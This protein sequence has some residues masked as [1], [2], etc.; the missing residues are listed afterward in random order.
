MSLLS[1]IRGSADGLVDFARRNIE[2]RGMR[3]EADGDDAV[4]LVDKDRGVVLAKF[5]SVDDMIESY[6][7]KT[8]DL[9]YGNADNYIDA[10]NPTGSKVDNMINLNMGD[11]YGMLPRGATKVKSEGGINYYK[12]GND[13]YATTY[14]PDVGEEDVI[15]YHLSKDGSAELQVVNEMKGKGIG[16]ELSYQFRKNNPEA[17]SGGLSEAGERTARKT[18]DR[19]KAEG[20]VGG[21]AA[22]GLLAASPESEA[23]VASQFIRLVEAGYPESTARKIMSGELPMDFN[24]RMN[25]ARE[26]GRTTTAYRVGGTGEDQLGRL[27][28]DPSAGFAQRAGGGVWFSQDAPLTLSYSRPEGASYKSLLDTSNFGQVDAGG[29]NWNDIYDTDFIFPDGTSIHIDD[30]PELLASQAPTKEKRI[31]IRTRGAINTTDKLGRAAR[32]LGLSGVEIAQVR[33]IGPSGPFML[34]NVKET[35]EG[36]DW[37]NDY[38][39]YGGTN[40]SVQDPSTIRSY[41]GAAF[42]PDEIGNPN[43]MASRAPVGAVGGLLASEAATPEGQLNPLLAIPAEIGSAL[44]EALVGTVDFLGPDTVNAVSELI[45]SEYRMPR[46][47]DQELVRLYSQGGYMD[48]GYGR[49]AIRT[50]TGLLSP[51]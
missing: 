9:I 41:Y 5:N 14:N 16:A 34:K 27:E 15:G 43:I 23:G 29:Q 31:A 33:D 6:G 37:I 44:N 46:L 12:D 3:I 47:S 48:E 21:T 10:I 42:D 45:G 17:P 36:K 40:Y 19:L 13:F 1:I 18:Y 24:S 28:F 8:P 20:I 49:D 22:L 25:R 35:Q 2:E 50:A 26:Q 4:K 39:M 7:P 32:D 51:L 30:L 38:E 11:M